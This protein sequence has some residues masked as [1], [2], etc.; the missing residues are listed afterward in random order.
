VPAE[1]RHDAST[2]RGQPL[3]P[4]FVVPCAGDDGSPRAVLLSRKY[5]RKADS[6]SQD[7]I[8]RTIQQ[9]PESQIR[10]ATGIRR[11]CR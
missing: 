11:R 4:P 3:V 10:P 2:I 5:T 6:E 1:S 9:V 7:R 8:V